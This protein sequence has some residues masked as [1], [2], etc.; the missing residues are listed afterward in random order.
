MKRIRFC[1]K[2]TLESVL[3]AHDFKVFNVYYKCFADD[4]LDEYYLIMS[5]TPILWVVL[6]F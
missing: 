1:K 6:L 2:K 3:N 4:Q 5:S